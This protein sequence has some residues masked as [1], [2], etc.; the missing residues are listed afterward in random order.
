MARKRITVTKESDSGRNREFR[1]NVTGEHMTR[2]QLV[3]KIK[4]GQYDDYHV[5]KINGLD[6]PVSN[7]NGRDNDNLG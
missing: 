1:D 4:K 6:T 7:P 5:R 2:A 3:S